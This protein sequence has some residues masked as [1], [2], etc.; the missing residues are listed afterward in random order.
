M[1]V[2]A[3]AKTVFQNFGRGMWLQPANPEGEAHV[4]YVAG[5]VIV[6]ATRLFVRCNDS[7]RQFGSL[8]AHAVVHHHAFAL[9]R[10][11][12][13]RNLLPAGESGKLDVRLGVDFLWFVAGFAL[14]VGG[15]ILDEPGVDAAIGGFT[16]IILALWAFQL[17][18]TRFRHVDFKTIFLNNGLLGKRML[19]YQNVA[20]SR[21]TLAL[22]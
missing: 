14:S 6:K 4:A 9:Q 7:P 2:F 21:C 19:V 8:F 3:V 11:V 16:D 20:G 13:M 12:P 5:Y 10:G 18:L 22:T 1:L 15:E 17:H